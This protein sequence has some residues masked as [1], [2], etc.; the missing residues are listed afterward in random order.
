MVE[1]CIQGFFSVT[2][3]I[4]N[5]IIGTVQI[6]SINLGTEEGAAVGQIKGTTAT[7]TGWINGRLVV[8]SGASYPSSPAE[9]E[10]FVKTDVWPNPVHAALVVYSAS[11]WRTVAALY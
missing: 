2:R 10:L 8:P 1:Q 7:F 4:A 9:G 11:S 6:S 5:L 3:T